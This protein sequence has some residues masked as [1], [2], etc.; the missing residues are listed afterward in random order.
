LSSSSCTHTAS[1]VQQIEPLAEWRRTVAI[2]A[3]GTSRWHELVCS[4][5]LVSA[6]DDGCSAKVELPSILPVH[7]SPFVVIGLTSWKRCQAG[8]SKE[9]HRDE[10]CIAPSSHSRCKRPT[11]RSKRPLSSTSKTTPN[12]EA[13]L[14]KAAAIS[15]RAGGDRST[16][17]LHHQL[18][19]ETC[20]LHPDSQ[21]ISRKASLS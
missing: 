11:S 9:A 18:V 17:R 12:A 14:T 10:Y 21:V 7:I 15:L 6:Q 2:L 16:Y 13:P 20:C 1:D 4:R 3:Q 5:R 19:V 8:R